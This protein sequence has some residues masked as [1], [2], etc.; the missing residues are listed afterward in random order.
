M[1]PILLLRTETCRRPS[2]VQHLKINPQSIGNHRALNSPP[3]RVH[4]PFSIV[5]DLLDPDH[6]RWRNRWAQNIRKSQH[7]HQTDSARHHH[8]RPS[9]SPG[10]LLFPRSDT[11]TELA[12]RRSRVE[13]TRQAFQVSFHVHSALIT[14]IA[15]L[16]Q[17]AR[18]NMFSQRRKFGPDGANGR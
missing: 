5:R 13:I 1:A 12:E 7:E 16:F 17:S 8:N 11:E 15:V 6:A 2:A 3:F 14:K 10:P 18:H 9:T 4:L